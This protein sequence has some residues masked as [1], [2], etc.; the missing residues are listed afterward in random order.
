[1]HFTRKTALVAKRGMRV[2][3]EMHDMDELETLCDSLENTAEGSS[4]SETIDWIFSSKLNNYEDYR[5]LLSLMW[6]GIVVEYLRKIGKKVSNFREDPRIT[7]LRHW[8][9]DERF[10]VK[11][12]GRVYLPITSR[13]TE[14][15][16]WSQNKNLKVGSFLKAMREK[17]KIMKAMERKVT[18]N[19]YRT[20]LVFFRVLAE[21]RVLEDKFRDYL[22]N[23]I[24]R[25]HRSEADA[26]ED[27]RRT[28]AS[29]QVQNTLMR[30]YLENT[31]TEF[32]KQSLYREIAN[33]MTS[34]CGWLEETQEHLVR[35]AYTYHGEIK[36]LE[37]ML[38]LEKLKNARLEMR[39]EDLAQS[40]KRLVT[41][42]D[43]DVQNMRRNL[44]SEL[45]MSQMERREKQREYDKLLVNFLNVR[46]RSNEQIERLRMNMEEVDQRFGKRRRIVR[47]KKNRNKKGKKG[48]GSKFGKRGVVKKKKSSTTT[49]LPAIVRGRSKRVTSRRSQRSTSARSTSSTESRSSVSSSSRKKKTKNSKKKKK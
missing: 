38:R 22:L 25:S 14:I 35:D 16:K 3:L 21:I 44:I 28:A 13:R 36:R 27:R 33:D 41:K 19:D 46:D 39:F 6:E 30:E 24:T 32:A 49:K 10:Q 12:F 8:M 7:V 29:F 34:T 23:E 9:Q 18:N 31:E 48:T 26:I 20:T 15:A 17:E 40:H 45:E 47:K 1:M 2:L 5:E 11:G 43:V 37:E 42:L 4:K